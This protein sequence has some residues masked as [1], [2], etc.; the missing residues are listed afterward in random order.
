ML[1]YDQAEE[2]AR[3]GDSALSRNISIRTR[4]E[5]YAFGDL[6][7]SSDSGRAAYT[8]RLSDL[9]GDDIIQTQVNKIEEAFKTEYGREIRDEELLDQLNLLL[10]RRP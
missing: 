10:R 3:K 9:F 6:T 2:L 1:T 8:D 7:I 4:P 5:S